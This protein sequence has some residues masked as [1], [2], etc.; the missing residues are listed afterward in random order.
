[1]TAVATAGFKQGLTASEMSA[2]TSVACPPCFLPPGTGGILCAGGSLVLPVGGAGLVG[3]LAVAV[4]LLGHLRR[5]VRVAAVV[6]GWGLQGG[7]FAIFAEVRG[8]VMYMGEGV[9]GFELVVGQVSSYPDSARYLRLH[10]SGGA[11]CFLIPRSLFG[12][13]SPARI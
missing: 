5:R 1:M 10:L 12:E 13:P 7:G 11:S 2:L 6:G 8:H 3:E 4:A 9:T